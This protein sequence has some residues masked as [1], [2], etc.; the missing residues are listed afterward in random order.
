MG[1]EPVQSTTEFQPFSLKSGMWRHRLHMFLTSNNKTRPWGS[2]EKPPVSWQRS[3]SYSSATKGSEDSFVTGAIPPLPLSHSLCLTVWWPYPLLVLRERGLESC[4]QTQVPIGVTSSHLFGSTGCR[5]S[6]KD[7]L[8]NS[9]P[10]HCIFFR[11][12]KIW[13]LTGW[14]ITHF[15]PSS[16]CSSLLTLQ[17]VREKVRAL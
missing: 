13:E 2:S 1:S 15:L 7:K 4:F 6:E 8:S 12:L 5:G 10:N 9:H 11:A 16:Q 3:D 17:T 14:G